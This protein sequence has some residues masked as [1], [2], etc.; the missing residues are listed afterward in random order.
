M[1]TEHLLT[2][3]KDVSHV[4]LESQGV[5]QHHQEGSREQRSIQ[6]LS[7]AAWPDIAWHQ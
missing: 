4:V 3:L 5:Q 6:S 2:L 7:Y 1:A